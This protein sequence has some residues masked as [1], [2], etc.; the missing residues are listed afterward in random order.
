MHNL[1]EIEKKFCTA[2]INTLHIPAAA[3]EAGCSVERANA[4]LK[5]AK[6]QD[7]L[8][9]LREDIINDVNVTPQWVLQKLTS[10]VYMSLEPQR[11]NY[12]PALKALELLGKCNG[13]FTDNFNINQTKEKITRVINVNASTK[14]IKQYQ[15]SKNNSQ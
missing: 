6:V 9:R 2:Y 11:P 10:I 3:E 13:M 1:T 7:E 15:E 8:K 5:S 12:A 14:F 4:L